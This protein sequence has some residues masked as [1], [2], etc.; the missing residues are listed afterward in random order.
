MS[1][2]LKE[3]DVKIIECPRDAMQGILDFIPTQQKIAYINKLLTVGFHTLDCGSFVSP[4]AMPQMRDTK[5]VL[6]AL[7]LGQTETKLS[8]IVAN[9]RGAD[10]AVQFSQVDYL[11]FPFS[12]SETFQ[13]RNTNKTIYNSLESVKYIHDKCMAANKEMVVYISMGF[14]NPYGDDWSASAVSDWVGKLENIGIRHFSLSDTV[15]ISTTDSIA[16]VFKLVN[17]HTVGSEFGG[18]FHTKPF[19]WRDKIDSAYANGC[20]KFDGAIKGYGGCPMAKDDLVGNMPTE[21]MLEYFGAEK[22]QLKKAP[23]EEAFLLAE[24]IFNCYL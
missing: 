4:R 12:I 8:V 24:N 13:R 10:E 21:R 14:G 2:L 9:R 19:D 3:P 16:E 22:L 6:N 11:G 18:H 23:F 15:G 20:R 5:E 17:K 7:D 1:T